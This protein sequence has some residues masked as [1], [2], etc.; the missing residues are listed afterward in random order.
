MKKKLYNSALSLTK[1]LLSTVRVIPSPA[2]SKTRRFVDGQARALK[3]ACQFQPAAENF[4]FHCASLGE[5]AIARPLMAEL[6]RRKPDCRIAL[7]FFSSTGVMALRR[8]PNPD[9]D[10]VGFL[11]LDTAAN[12]YSLLDAFRPSA[13]LFM[14]SEYWPNYLAEL[15]RRNIPTFLVSCIFTENTPHFKPVIGSIFRDSLQTYTRIYCLNHASVDVLNRLGYDRAV[16]EGDPLVDNALRI[17]DTKWD[18]PALRQ[19]CHKAPT[20]ICGSIHNGDD[21]DLIAREINSHPSRRYLLVPHEVDEASLQ[22]VEE[23]LDVHSRRLSRYTPTMDENVLIVDNIGQLA[24]LYRYGTMAYVGGGF[25]RQL[26]SIIEPAVYGLPIAFGPRTE[27]KVLAKLLL[28]L[29]VATTTAT[30]AQ[31][32]EWADR[33]FNAP[34]TQLEEIRATARKFC[35]EQAGAT[36]RIISNVLECLKPTD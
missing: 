31:F 12:A 17:A 20:L 21:I 29:G 35:D 30:P 34:R 7:T 27:R 9:A 23:A 18:S 33:L 8:R 1:G 26:H 25:T 2:L 10:Y 6:K 24:Y 13:A 3:N 11:P 16:V 28:K 15:K 22:D 4:W 14:V 36:R 32:A 19:F 5:Y